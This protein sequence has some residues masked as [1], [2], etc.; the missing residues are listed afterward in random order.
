MDVRASGDLRMDFVLLDASDSAVSVRRVGDC[1][2]SILQAPSG[3]TPCVTIGPE[4]RLSARVSEQPKKQSR[5]DIVECNGLVLVPRG[6]ST[7][8]ERRHGDRHSYT[9]TGVSP[10]RP[11]TKTEP[12]KAHTKSQPEFAP[13]SRRMHHSQQV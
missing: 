6:R 4:P 2:R 11:K 5:L 13:P 12:R 3:H 1:G 10:P 7:A 8:I 9:I